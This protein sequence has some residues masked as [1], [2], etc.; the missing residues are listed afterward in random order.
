MKRFY[1]IFLII[2]L[3]VGFFLIYNSNHL[4]PSPLSL[5]R[6]GVGERSENIKYVEIAGQSLKVD[7]ALTQEAQAR[8]LSGRA[9]LGENEGMLFIFD[10]PGRYPFWMKDMNFPIDI[11]W[12]GQDD[13]VVFIKK[14][15]RP[16]LYPE[17]YGS[18]THARYVL[19]VV[20]GFSDKYNLQPGDKAV[21]H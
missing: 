16:E 19:E 5:P 20:S 1:F 11:I 21:F 10:S 13:K 17:T 7:V 15:A 12:I 2:F 6:R 3:L 14:D 8:G 4:T 9:G 18:D